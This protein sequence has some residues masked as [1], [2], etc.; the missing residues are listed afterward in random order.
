MLSLIGDY[1]LLKVLLIYRHENNDTYI[2]HHE[3][4]NGVMD[5]G[6]PLTARMATELG[7]KLFNGRGKY[8]SGTI[9]KNMLYSSVVMD[10]SL[11]VWTTEAC[12]K[13]LLFNG[14]SLKD[15]LYP[16]PPMI[17]RYHNGVLTVMAVNKEGALCHA[18]F[19]NLSATGVVCMGSANKF[20]RNE[21]F[22]TFH[23][24]MQIC[25]N[26]F[27]QSKFT[28]FIKGFSPVVGNVIN[29]FNSLIDQPEFPD[30]ILKPTKL[31]FEQ[32][33]EQHRI[34]E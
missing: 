24:C 18:P 3:I 14:I 11:V 4:V 12:T 30:E 23:Q 22:K 1:N 15:G 34:S 7:K 20:I 5:V 16:I 26:A 9:P 25:E 17:W 32:F 13:T 29:V 8:L 33:Y 6:K 28:H 27:F 19:G 2:E 10:A 31:K 21:R